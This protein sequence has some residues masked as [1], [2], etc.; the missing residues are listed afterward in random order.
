MINSLIFLLVI[1]NPFYL[2]F[3]FPLQNL[4]QEIGFRE[5]ASWE[6]SLASALKNA[7][8]N[9][10]P[11]RNWGIDDPGI[12][13]QAAGIFSFNPKAEKNIS[14]QS[15][16][17][18]F[19]Q[20]QNLILPIASL[21]KLMTAV[22]VLE[23]LK[24][25]ELNQEIIVSE[26]AVSVFGSQ[27][28]LQAGERLTIKNILQA[29]LIESSND[30]AYVLA[31]SIEQKT[32]KDFVFLM[33]QKAKELGLKNTRFADPSGLNPANISTVY[34]IA[35]LVKYSFNYPLIWQITKTIQIDVVSLGGEKHTWTNTDKLLN[36]YQNIIAA[37]AL[38]RN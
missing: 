15:N 7:N 18:L 23:E 30:A 35:C 2:F 13:S 16:E 24:E 22:V 32:E 37:K 28:G 3:S 25:T 36:K 4:N 27:A 14:F 19:Y 9:F 38:F 20:N 31:E 29:L 10:L 26:N 6:K 8:P 12:E 11:I 34:D 1:A 33:N 17:I 21:T 5:L